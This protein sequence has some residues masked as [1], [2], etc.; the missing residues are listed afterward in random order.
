M[1]RHTGSNIKRKPPTDKEPSMKPPYAFR[2]PLSTL[3]LVFALGFPAVSLAMPP[4]LPPPPPPLEQ[5]HNLE[6]IAPELNMPPEQEDLWRTAE[7]ASVEAAIDRGYQQRKTDKWLKEALQD[8]NL[9]LSAIV[10]KLGPDE[11]VL[12][13]EQAVRER[14]AA[15]YDSLNV[16]QSGQ[17]RKFILARMAHNEEMAKKIR[18]HMQESGPF[19]PLAFPGDRGE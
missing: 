11:G 19:L 18:L 3:V 4:Q 10:R 14:W 8:N 9:P 7:A 15:F 13:R 5:L 1:L 6:E 17:I 2:Q 12:R 16:K